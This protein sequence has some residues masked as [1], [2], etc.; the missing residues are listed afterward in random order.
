MAWTYILGCLKHLCMYVT[1]WAANLVEEN[2]CGLQQDF[3]YT[4]FG[5]HLMLKNIDYLLPNIDASIYSTVT[6]GA[7]PETARPNIRYVVRIAYIR[8][9]IRLDIG[10][11]ILQHVLFPGL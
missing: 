4:D 8:M 6:V 3:V 10:D 9:E 11:V 1:R 2:S 5:C 7:T